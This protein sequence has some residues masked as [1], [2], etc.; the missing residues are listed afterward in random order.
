M[1]RVFLLSSALFYEKKFYGLQETGW[2][3]EEI[4]EYN[5]YLCK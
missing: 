3:K 1:V 4:D 5:Q 2:Q